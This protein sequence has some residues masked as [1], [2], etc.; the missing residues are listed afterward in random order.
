M[1][2]DLDFG[3]GRWGIPPRKLDVFLRGLSRCK[4]LRLEG[5]SAHL[6]YVPGKN[7]VEAEEKLRHIKKWNQNYDAIA[8]PMAKQLEGLRQ[9]LDYNLPK[10]ITFLVQAGRTLDAYAETHEPQSAPSAAAPAPAPE[11]PP[12]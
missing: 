7:T 4:R 3:L 12:A 10:G 8:D 5:L 2:V 9:F 1:H 6:A 11:A